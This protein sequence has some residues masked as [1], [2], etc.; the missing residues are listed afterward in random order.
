MKTNRTLQVLDNIQAIKHSR[1]P[2]KS[3]PKVLTYK[4]KKD[5]PLL[6]EGSITGFY[7]KKGSKTLKEIEH[8]FAKN[9]AKLIDAVTKKIWK[10]L[11]NR[12]PFKLRASLRIIESESVMGELRYGSKQLA[13]NLVIPK[14]IDFGAV[15]FPYNGGE[16]LDKEFE[17]V[18]FNK[19][20]HLNDHLELILIKREPVLSKDELDALAAVPENM[21]EMNVSSLVCPGFCVA[22]VLVITVITA[23]GQACMKGNRIVIH[24]DDIKRLGPMASASELLNLRRQSFYTR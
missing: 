24:T 1:L 23:L 6:R 11:N 20:E 16:L 12:E 9:D 19:Y 22:I 8:A 3:T 21:L 18:E 2:S 15:V 17:F 5:I 10:D 7:A 4:G 14:G 13:D